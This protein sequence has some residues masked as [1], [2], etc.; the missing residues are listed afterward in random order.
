[1][2]VISGQKRR[3]KRPIATEGPGPDFLGFLFRDMSE[4]EGLLIQGHHAVVRGMG[5]QAQV[6]EH[7]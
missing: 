7:E 3:E 1:M 4:K 6:R 5:F 2:L